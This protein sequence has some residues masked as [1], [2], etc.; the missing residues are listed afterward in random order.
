MLVFS[1]TAENGK[2]G[3]NKNKKELYRS[4]KPKDTPTG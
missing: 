2:R 4:W 1:S 3:Q